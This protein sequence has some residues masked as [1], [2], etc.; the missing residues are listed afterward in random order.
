MIENLLVY[1]TLTGNTEGVAQKIQTLLSQ[2]G[3]TVE[4]KNVNQLEVEELAAA[5]NSLIIATST[6][7]DGLP[8]SD[9]VEFLEEHAGQLPSLT[10]KKLALFGCGDSNY[11]K[12]CGGLTVL[13]QEFIQLGGQKVIEPLRIDGFPE[14]EENQNKIIAWVEQ[15]AGLI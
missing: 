6:W 3:K 12:F 14:G 15:L 2:K 13:E 5:S 4:L 10:A 8:C 9:W 11:S 7:D 1:G